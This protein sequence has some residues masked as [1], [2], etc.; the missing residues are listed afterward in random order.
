VSDGAVAKEERGTEEKVFVEMNG[1]ERE[2]GI[3][4]AWIFGVDGE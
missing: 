4:K 1:R 2:V 3:K